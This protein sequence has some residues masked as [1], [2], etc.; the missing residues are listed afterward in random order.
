MSVRTAPSAGEKD[1][2][3][4][5]II[6]ALRQYPDAKSLLHAALRLLDDTPG[7]PLAVGLRK[8][9]QVSGEGRNTL[10]LAIR[11]GELES[12]KD[13][14][15]PNSPRK[16]IYRSLKRRIARRLLAQA[17]SSK[18]AGPSQFKR[19]RGTQLTAEI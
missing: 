14:T 8:A 18:A 1:D 17:R 7:E 19:G 12:Y 10:W 9:M 13:G 5:G 11:A 16:I 4:N 3:Y 2:L 15:R 6:V